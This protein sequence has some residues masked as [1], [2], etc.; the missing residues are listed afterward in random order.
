MGWPKP[1]GRGLVLMGAEK[2]REDWR[3]W[4]TDGEKGESLIPTHNK[5]KNVKP[6]KNKAVDPGPVCGV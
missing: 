1:G 4:V 2:G 6:T 3:K 5:Q